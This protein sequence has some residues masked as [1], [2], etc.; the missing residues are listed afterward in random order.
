MT[1]KIVTTVSMQAESLFLFMQALGYRPARNNGGWITD[2]PYLQGNRNLSTAT[3]IKLHNKDKRGWEKLTIPGAP[4]T[5]YRPKGLNVDVCLSA[6]GLNRLLS[7]KLV[8]QVKFQAS[9]KYLSGVVFPQDEHANMIKPV[10][11]RYLKDFGIEDYSS[12]VCGML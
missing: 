12:G 11:K 10:D 7:A 4:G 6:Y 5:W 2:N 1:F 8:E 3:A 9:N